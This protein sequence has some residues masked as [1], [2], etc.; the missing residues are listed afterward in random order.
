MAFAEA[1]ARQIGTSTDEFDQATMA[2]QPAI[3][4]HRRHAAA[5]GTPRLR[6]PAVLV[7]VAALALVLIGGV[8]AAAVVTNHNRQEAAAH[9][10][11]TAAAP[12]AP[13]APSAPAAPAVPVVLIGADCATLGAAG[14][15]TSGQTAYCARLPSTGDTMWS[16]YNGQ[17][18]DPTVTP[19]PT[20][21]MY[22]PGIEQQV[23]VCVQQT[24]HS[25]VQCRQEI[26]DGNLVGPP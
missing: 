18:P 23:A 14:Q 11:P 6:R 13:P 22:A 25:R 9:P 1:F 8:V 4:P 26:R 7:P 24:G 21:Q 3:T 15:S 2:A 12:A 16:L 17:V 5:T 10:P 19:G 20:D